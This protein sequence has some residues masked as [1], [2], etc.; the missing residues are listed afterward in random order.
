[1]DLQQTLLLVLK[2]VRLSVHHMKRTEIT[3]WVVMIVNIGQ[4]HYG[5]LSVKFSDMDVFV[6]DHP[7]IQRQNSILR[8]EEPEQTNSISIDCSSY[9]FEALRPLGS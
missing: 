5:G 7:L 9:G 2:R 1:M 6:P 3:E 4:Y 8:N